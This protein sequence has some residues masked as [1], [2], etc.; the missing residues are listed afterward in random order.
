MELKHHGIKGM[1]WGIRRYQNEDGSLTNSGKKRYARDALEK[2]FNKYDPS[3]NKYY[4][5]SKKNGRTDLEF[6]PSRYVEEDI[7][8]SKKLVDEASNLTRTLKNA[9]DALTNNKPKPQMN[10]SEM[11]DQEL[12]NQIN[13]KL[14]EKQYNDIFNPDKVSKGQYYT[15]KVL[16]TSGA[17]LAAG[18]SALGMALS[19]K[20]LMG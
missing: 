13:R 9:N 6:N 20:K 17:I 10:L 4:K 18:S 8:R 5:Q 1:K 11:S 7:S 3:T 16:E 2:D 14:L 12:R 15:K 19:I